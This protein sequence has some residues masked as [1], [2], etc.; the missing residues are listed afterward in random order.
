[1][2]KTTHAM[3]Y[4]PCWNNIA[5]GYL[6]V[7]AIQIFLRQHCTRKLLAQCLPRAHRIL[8]QE[9][10]LFKICLAACF[11][12]GMISPSNLG[13]F[14][15]MLA[16]VSFMACG[17]TMNRWTAIWHQQSSVSLKYTMKIILLIYFTSG[18]SP[19]S[20]FHYNLGICIFCYTFY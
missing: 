13:S 17:T 18:E 11:L 15:S 20:I 16:W 9:N 4:Q 19:P 10:R 14:C 8:S 7:N 3:L 6:L 2:R 5:Y 12:T 1:M